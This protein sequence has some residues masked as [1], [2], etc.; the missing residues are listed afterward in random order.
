MAF[1]HQVRV[2]Y[3]EVDAQGVVFNAH[4][5]TYFDDAVTRFFE[6]MGYPPKEAFSHQ[7][8]FDLMLRRSDLEWEGS[9]GFDDLVEIA[10]VPVRLG[11]SSFDVRFTATVDGR[12][13][14]TALTTYVVVVPGE[15]RSQPIPDDLRERLTERSEAEP[16]TT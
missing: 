16:A 12:P 13:A 3:A 7:S 15:P 2:R 5:L 4:W 10:V 8:H 14:V 6:N 11:K 1:V 9:A